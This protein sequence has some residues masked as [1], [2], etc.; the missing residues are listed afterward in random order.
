MNRSIRM[1]A[2]ALSLV[3]LLPKG[4]RALLFNTAMAK[5]RRTG[6]LLPPVHL[7]IEPTNA[8]N[9]RCP[10]CETGNRSMERSTGMMAL[11]PYKR[12]IDNAAPHLNTLLFYFMG[13]P[14][15]NKHA[16]EMIRYARNRD[17]F[18]ET[19]TN[20]EPV[21]PKGVIHSDINL[22]SFQIGG[23]TQ[24]TH[25]VYRV[26]GNL[27]KTQRILVETI[28]ERN[29]HPGSNM[30]IE[31]GF[32]VMRHNEHEVPEF[33]RWAK[34]IG[35]DTVNVINPCVR[36]VEE[37]Q[38]LLPKDRTYWF[39]NEA[40]FAKGILRP[41]VLPHNECSW[42]WNSLL[43]NWDGGVIPCCRDPH[44][45]HTFGNA[46]DQPLRTIWNGPA[47]RDFRQRILDDQGAIDI[48]RLCSGFGLPDLL[49]EKP[50]SLIQSVRHRRLEEIPQGQIK[51]PRP[52]LNSP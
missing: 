9:L 21:D 42:V 32:I 25:Q 3:R 28:E 14:F 24:E 47:M 50:T 41:K 13:E 4:W 51:M 27:E 22:I 19:C 7:S 43:I 36:S 10:V 37:G 48:C 33:L 39:Y 49:H 35:A 15:L 46:F 12:L 44:G 38:Q 8:C 20:G 1:M 30:V 40:Y 52:P 23:M 34:E 18:V 11:E 45:R 26:K 31:A 17:I 5:A 29:R 6:P 2:K 16:Y